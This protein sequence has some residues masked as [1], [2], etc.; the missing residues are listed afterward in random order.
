MI[1]LIFLL[2]FLLSSVNNGVYVSVGVSTIMTEPSIIDDF[3]TPIGILKLS[4][5]LREGTRLFIRHASSIPSTSDNLPGG[6]MN[7]AGIE[8]TYYIGS[9][10]K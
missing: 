9:I 2:P 4:T 7:E 1:I 10:K 8:F 3:K 5:E 6:G